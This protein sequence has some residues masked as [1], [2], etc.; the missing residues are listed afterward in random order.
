MEAVLA[1]AGVAAFADAVVAYEPVWAI[2]TG[3]TA[4]PEQ[5]QLVHA[6]IR[7]MIAARDAT[8]AAGLIILYGGS[9]K[10]SNAADLFAKEDIDGGLVGGASLEASEF[11]TIFG[12]AASR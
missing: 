1:A 7:R 6:R 4:T 2:G 12:A 8:I 5:A 9:V 10:G 3:K 11:L